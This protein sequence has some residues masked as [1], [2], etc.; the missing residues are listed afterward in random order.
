MYGSAMTTLPPTPAPISQLV[1]DRYGNIVPTDDKI[2]ATLKQHPGAYRPVSIGNMIGLIPHDSV[3]REGESLAWLGD[4]SLYPLVAL[5]AALGQD[6]ETGR[7]V[8]RRGH[9]ERVLLIKNGDV[10]SVASTMPQD[11]LGLFLTRIGKISAADVDAATKEA[12]QQGKR[13]GQVLI[14]K[15]LLDAHALWLCIKHQTTEIVADVVQWPRGNF[16]FYR[17]PKEYRFPNSPGMQMQMLLLEALRRSDE[18]R[19]FRELIPDASVRLRCTAFGPEASVF[20][21]TQPDQTTADRVWER[22]R[23][24]LVNPKHPEEADELAL[25]ILRILAVHNDGLSITLLAQMIQRTEFDATKA[26][27]AL[28]KHKLAVTDV[29]SRQNTAQRLQAQNDANRVWLSIQKRRMMEMYN[30]AMRLIQQETLVHGHL[31]SFIVGVRQYISNTTY[32][33]RKVFW[34]T[35]P[36]ASGALPID[37][38]VKNIDK[39]GLI[40]GLD[41]NDKN[42]L[43]QEAL[44]DVVF[45][46]LFQCGTLLDPVVEDRLG[47]QVRQILSS[48]Q[49]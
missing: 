40:D 27:Y 19:V 12:E 42:K 8:V 5:L 26:S 49:A 24:V 30:E 31:E 9:D 20:D 1:V 29:E 10:V 39:E 15:K 45:F 16:L 48:A 36:D 7:L 32:P 46:M 34:G 23:S 28:L 14:Q 21:P 18:M 37:T 3:G 6:R 44:S 13:L 4:L 22:A 38:L 11:R 33:Y 17:L 2:R 43:L 47:Q 35:A 25:Q 41:A